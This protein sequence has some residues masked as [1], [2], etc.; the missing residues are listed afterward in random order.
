MSALLLQR[1]PLGWSHYVTLLSVP[2]P[3]AR[4]FYE[5]EAAEW[6]RGSGRLDRRYQMT[7]LHT[8]STNERIHL[9]AG[10]MSYEQL[11]S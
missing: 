2:N 3:D 10:S 7:T 8:L 1:F 4:R 5:I 11:S 6:R 9:G